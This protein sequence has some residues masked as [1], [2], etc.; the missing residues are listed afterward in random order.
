M[1]NEFEQRRPAI[2]VSERPYAG[3]CW[4]FYNGCN[5]PELQTE[6]RRLAR[7]LALDYTDSLDKKSSTMLLEMRGEQ[8]TD[9]SVHDY[10]TNR[11][12]SQLDCVG[13]RLIAHYLLITETR[14]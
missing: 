10:T 2:A 11:K 13:L 3:T 8:P 4:P 14:V 7:E 1:A 9:Q 5:I 6:Y 12:R